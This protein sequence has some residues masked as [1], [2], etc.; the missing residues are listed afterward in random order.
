MLNLI[1]YFNKVTQLFAT[2]LH[3]FTKPSKIFRQLVDK[4]LTGDRSAQSALY[5]SLAEQMYAVCIRLSRSRHEADDI[6]QEGF[7]KMF[8]SLHQY[9]D[10]GSFEGWVRKIMVNTAL[11]RYR[12][13]AARHTILNLS[14]VSDYIADE[15]E[16]IV[17]NLAAKELEVLI[18]ELPTA[19]R[20][21]FNLY[22]FEGYQHKEIAEMLN[23]SEGTSKSNLHDARKWLRE[24]LVKAKKKE[25]IK[26][27][28]L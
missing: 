24:K 22:V 16:D 21:V 1:F 3:L 13:Q 4:C 6:L 8:S 27:L 12:S 14:S 19:Y 25:T 17:S 11:Q 2:C 26:G 23:I 5:H 28:Y 7:I 18:Q 20:M 10:L 15:N 9:G